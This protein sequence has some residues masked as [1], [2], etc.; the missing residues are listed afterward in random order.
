MLIDDA[1]QVDNSFWVIGRNDRSQ[2]RKM[3]PELIAHTDTTQPLILLDHQPYLLRDAEKNG[4][5]LQISGHTHNGQVWPINL[6]VKRIFEVG[7]GYKQKGN[8]HIYTTSGLAL[9]GA[10]ARIGTQSEMVVFNLQFGE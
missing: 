2:K 9:W 5:D 8:T 3:L 4:I 1:V 10:P 7:Y 6:L